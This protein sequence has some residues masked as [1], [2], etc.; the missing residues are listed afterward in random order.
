MCLHKACNQKGEKYLVLHVYQRTVYMVHM[1]STTLNL[2]Q[3]IFMKL[4]HTANQSS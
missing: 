4:R 3:F 2:I 1:V